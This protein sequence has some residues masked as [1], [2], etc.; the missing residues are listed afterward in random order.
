MTQMLV[1]VLNHLWQSTLVAGLAWLLCRTMLK[2]NS[3][4]VRF[5]VWLA[6]GVKFLVPFALLVGVGQSLGPTLT[7]PQSQQVLDLVTQENRSIAISPFTAPRT[8]AVAPEQ[9]SSLPW[10]AVLGVVWALGA[11]VV[12]FQWL[13]SWWRIR[14]AA[15]TAVPAGDF[16]GI[17]ILASP[18]LRSATIE[19]GVFGLWSPVILIPEGLESSL[20]DRQFRAV[21]EHER[22]HVHRRDNLTAL[23]Q[24]LTEVVF[25]FYP[26]VWLIGRKLNEERELICDRAVL[27]HASPDDVEAYAEGMLTICKLYAASPLPC[28]T[29]ITGANLRARI[30][31]ILRNERPRSLNGSR[32]W[33]LAATLVTAVVTPVVMG[34]LT[35]P[36]VFAQQANSFQGLATVAEKKFEVATAKLNASGETRFQLGP[37][38]QGSIAITN[39]VLRGI[40]VQSFRTQR[41]MVVGIPGW[42]ETERYDIVGKG[43]DPKMT[44]PEVWEMMRSLLIERFHMKFH[45]E[46]RE[47]PVWALTIAPRGLKLTPGEN[48]ECKQQI[49]DKVPCGDIRVPPFG[50][51]MYNM[52]IGALI[53]GI[54]NRA[55]RPI[56][57]KT[58]LTGRYDANIRWLPDGV[59]FEDIPMNEIPVEFRPDDM[60]VFQALE[61]HAGLKLVE[62][63]APMPVV[64]IDSLS[65]P[66]AN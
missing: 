9:A 66:D 58:G 20:T 60:N 19:P 13:A 49:Q 37:P 23:L 62:E 10:V 4:N 40:V 25:W 50:T 63:R 36:A 27:E 61:A 29:G 54:G 53:T 7:L 52:P 14:R 46:N 45:V 15:K 59:K 3:P 8:S 56:V 11:G 43:P 1:F 51:A 64:V 17:P 57:D 34:F 16:H 24:M 35:A 33:L 44:N 65:R 22:T 55:G 42:A 31:G 21:L 47:M 18:M 2:T 32:R 30:E 12:T 5:A 48:G 26:V 6:A 41:D 38:G 39:V 28:V